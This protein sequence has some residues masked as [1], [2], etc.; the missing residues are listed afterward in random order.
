MSHDDPLGERM[1]ASY[2]HRARHML[3]RRTYTVV[4]LDGKAFHSYTRGLDRPFDARFVEDMHETAAWL[5]AQVSGCRL[6][7]TE[8]DEI[9][10]VLTD[11]ASEKTQAWFDGNQQKI[12]SISASMAT[13]KFNERRPG[14]LAFFDSRAFTIPDPVEVTNYLL[15]RQRD[16]YRNSVAMAAQ[17]HFPHK[18]LHGKSSGEMQDMLWRV[19]GVNWNDYD[20]R[21]KRGSLAVQVRRVGAVTYV[22]KR[23]GQTCHTDD[24][25][26]R[27]WLNEAAPLFG[28][29][30]DW[31]LQVLSGET[32]DEIPTDDPS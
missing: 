4:R 5:A 22:D 30:R 16:A 6:A 28:K 24:V 7:Y 1:K 32:P 8:S 20:P 29:T 27:V 2:E 31:L 9:S 17:A 12:V 21:F 11:F 13:A 23:T 14:K 15:W 18:Q 19:H 26:R 3:P 25:E 10:L